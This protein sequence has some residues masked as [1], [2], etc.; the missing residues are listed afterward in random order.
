MTDRGTAMSA[1]IPPY[2]DHECLGCDLKKKLVVTPDN[3]TACHSPEGWVCMKYMPP[4][5]YQVIRKGGPQ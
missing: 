4:K 5:A 1:R 2:P 3:R